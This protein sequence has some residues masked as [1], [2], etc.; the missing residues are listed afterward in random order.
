VI[1]RFFLIFGLFFLSFTP[2]QAKAATNI[3][4]GCIAEVMDV[5]AAKVKAFMAYDNAVSYEFMS[6]PDS[7]LALTC[8]HELARMSA[9]GGNTATNGLF[10]DGDDEFFSGDFVDEVASVINPSLKAHYKNYIVG[11]LSERYKTKPGLAYNDLYRSVN[12]S[13]GDLDSGSFECNAMNNLWDSYMAEGVRKG[14]PYVSFADLMKDTPPVGADGASGGKNFKEAWVAAAH[15][16]VFSS[17]KNKLEAL[18][19]KDTMDFSAS[20]TSCEVLITS[21]ILA[22]GSC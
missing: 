16:G 4:P 1:Y 9:S 7:V 8:F 14:V 11:T 19:P 3:T 15:E 13:G 6:K 18:P 17:L 12:P 22:S 10:K 2:F 5:I 20:K 21:G